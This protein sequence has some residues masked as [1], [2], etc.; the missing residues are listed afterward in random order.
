MEKEQIF[1]GTP[2]SGSIAKG[3]LRKLDNKITVHNFK[4]LVFKNLAS[5]Q[6]TLLNAI[7]RTKDEIQEL[8]NAIQNDLAKG[9]IEFQL[10]ILSDESFL[11]PI[12]DSITKDT[13]SYVTWQKHLN[14]EIDEYLNSDN[15]YLQARYIDLADIRDRVLKNLTTTPNKN[16]AANMS[17]S[18]PAIILLEDITPTEFLSLTKKNMVGIATIKGNLNS[19]VAILAQAQKI[20]MLIKLQTKLEQIPQSKTVI[21]NAMDGT[22]IC[23]PSTE[24][25]KKYQYHKQKF[26]EDEIAFEKILY[27]PCFTKDGKRIYVTINLDSVTILDKYRPQMCDGIGLV[28]TEFL[29]DEDSLADEQVQ[30]EEYKKIIEWA[31]NRPVYIRTLD[32]GGDKTTTKTDDELHSFLG[33]RGIRFS[34]AD[35]K[36]FEI[37]LRAL[38]RAA[39]LGDLKLIL[40]MVTIPDEI[41]TTKNIIDKITAQLSKENIEYAVPNIGMM[42]EVP[43]AAINIESFNVDFFSIG[44]NDL[45]QYITAAKRNSNSSYVN[46]LADPRNQAIGKL[47]KNIIEVA[48]KKSIT[49]CLCGQIASD[50]NFVPTLL[51]LGLIHFSVVPS[52]T[53]KIK[54]AISNYKISKKS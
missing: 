51:E 32:I 10:E 29:F 36:Q 52:M 1:I 45:I 2:T 40:P 31:D 17:I 9:I 35:K 8:T 27:E 22:F 7:N 24:S 16:E 50:P 15:Q 14:K 25:L 43:A 28:R 44:S 46:S 34:L 19:H 54:S 48:H 4:D 12:L 20:P 5:E 30:F 23:N 3:T 18:N 53:G 21:L 38:C 6:N 47:I 41:E 11:K 42:V 13:P 39:A 49:V 33:L 26:I 37:Q